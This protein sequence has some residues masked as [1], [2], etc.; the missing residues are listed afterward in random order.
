[1]RKVTVNC[2]IA[3]GLVS[4]SLPELFED[5]V[6]I[7]PHSVQFVNEGKHWHVVPVGRLELLPSGKNIFK[8]DFK[9]LEWCTKSIN[10]NDPQNIIF[11][12]STLFHVH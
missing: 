12:A 5:S 2:K 7:G 4:V 11:H 10:M 3:L 1:M 8:E 9:Q 6:W